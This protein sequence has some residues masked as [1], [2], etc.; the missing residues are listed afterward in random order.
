M[1][2]IVPQKSG[3]K[4]NPAICL[5]PNE[6]K[7]KRRNWKVIAKTKKLMIWYFSTEKNRIVHSDRL[8]PFLVRSS[9]S[10]II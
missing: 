2:F 4:L 10:R 8:A 9:D 1:K 7:K 5:I 3:W 6:E